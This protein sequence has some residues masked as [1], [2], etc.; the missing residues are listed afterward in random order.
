MIYNKYS[1]KLPWPII[2]DYLL[3]TGKSRDPREFVRQAVKNVSGII[4]FDQ[5][6]IFFFDSSGRVDDVE[7][8]DAEQT[9]TKAY[10]EYYADVEGG[11]YS[12]TR[13]VKKE[14]QYLQKLGVKIHD[15]TAEH[16]GEFFNDYIKPQSIHYSAGFMLLF[17]YQFYTLY[18][19]T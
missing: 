10:L 7:M 15:W 1:E 14:N 4:P 16:K 12:L 6:R 3:R 8:V 18:L 9:W 13:W 5:A 11:K 2:N 19:C 17:G